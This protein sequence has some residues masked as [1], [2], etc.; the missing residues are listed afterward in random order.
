MPGGHVEFGEKIE[1]AIK[2]EALEEVGLTDLKPLGIVSF[3]EVINSKEF[4]RPAHL[5][6]FDVLFKTTSNDIR[7]DI[8]ELQEFAWVKPQKAL[9][10][11]LAVGFAQ[12]IK[13]CIKF[14]KS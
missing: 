5:I 11:R 4:H 14:R 12:V 10:M 6:Y 2:R 1:D 3:G 8:K 9:K 13:D 7:L